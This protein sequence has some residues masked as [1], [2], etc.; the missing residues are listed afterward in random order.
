MS[1][2][3]KI[4]PCMNCLQLSL[5]AWT[6][7]HATGIKNIIF[8]LSSCYP[9]HYHPQ[10][11]IICNKT[12][13]RIVIIPLS[14][15]PILKIYYAELWFT[16][17]R[18]LAAMLAMHSLLQHAFAIC[19]HKSPKHRNEFTKLMP[20]I[21]ECMGGKLRRKGARLKYTSENRM[22]VTHLPLVTKC[23]KH[24]DGEQW[25]AARSHLL[26]HILHRVQLAAAH[27]PCI[28]YPYG[29]IQAGL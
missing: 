23:S 24:D 8:V 12:G 27:H 9:A 10:G 20:S 16:V 14:H 3:R 26:D 15:Y 17:C 7:A 21:S 6:H 4:N 22:P 25:T 19:W 28:N 18:W 5:A 2:R 29:K 13:R 1:A 11:V